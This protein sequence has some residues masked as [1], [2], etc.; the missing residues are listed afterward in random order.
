MVGIGCGI[1]GIDMKFLYNLMVGIK[2]V[3]GF[4]L[5]VGDIISIGDI[6]DFVNIIEVIVYG[7]GYIN[8]F[9]IVK[10]VG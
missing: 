7:E 8:I 6:K 3:L 4:I 2:V 1:C 5:E 9:I 10:N